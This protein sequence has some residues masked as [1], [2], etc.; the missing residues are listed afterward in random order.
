MLTGKPIAMEAT[1]LETRS[2]LPQNRQT[3][4]P[5]TAVAGRLRAMTVAGSLRGTIIAIVAATIST[6]AAVE[7]TQE[8]RT[9]E[10]D[11]VAQGSCCRV[12][13]AALLTGADLRGMAGCRGGRGR[14]Y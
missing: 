1:S 11:S 14:E 9:G 7:G 13:S 3:Q 8:N 10:G 5:T 2:V 12:Q 4:A 6:P